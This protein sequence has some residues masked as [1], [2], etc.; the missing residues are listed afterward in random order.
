MDR[1]ERLINLTAALLDAGAPVTR[2]DL[3]AT[4]PGYSGDAV[5]FRRA[6]E[7][8][9]EALRDM[10]IPLAL[11]PVDPAD[12][13]GPK[14]YRIPRQDY[15]LADPGL[16]RDELAA[17][18]LA[19]TAVRVE[20][21]EGQPALWKLGGAV[22][23]NAAGSPGGAA[24][25]DG[26]GS[27]GGGPNGTS[28]PGGGPEVPDPAAGTVALPGSEHLPVVF[29]AVTERR[30]LAFS[31]RGR[32]RRVDPWGLAFR[33]G[34]WYL[35]GFDHDR[36][37]ER[38][39]RLDRF[40]SEPQAGPPGAFERPAGG[41]ARPVAPW[42]AG[43]EEEVVA[44]ALIDADQAA[45]AVAAVGEEA[46][47]ERRPDGAVVLKLAVTNRGAFRSFVLGFLDHAEVLGPPEL[48]DDVV[49]WLEASC[50]D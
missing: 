19:A 21:A 41:G 26:S 49:A 4:V 23:P 34:H 17:L 9:K 1:L 37:E 35:A 29:G 18:R 14:G 15:E 3:R 47:A 39:F 13:E 42:Q 45:W 16:E 33:G 7:R 24:G 50:R 48:R 22:G 46:V 10:G 8:D 25:L 30:R 11:E 12:P 31:Y 38:S 6:F 44:T 27:G 2:E 43:D 40:G 32:D 36:G 20:G 28:G 5:T